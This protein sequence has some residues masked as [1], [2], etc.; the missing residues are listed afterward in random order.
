MADTNMKITDAS[1][2]TTMAG[3]DKMFV[4]SGGDLKQIELD[5]AV[6]A[7]EPVKTLNS[8]L[9]NIIC[10]NIPRNTPKDITSYYTDGSLWNRLNGSGGYQFLE[11]I[12]VGDYIKMSRAISAKNPDSTYQATGS[13]YVT[14]ASINGL[15]GN[16][17]TGVSYNHLVMVPGTG[18]GGTQ[19]FG[20]SYMNSSHTTTGGYK[21]SYMNTTLLGDV[22]SSG[23]TASGATINQQLYA[24]F[25]SHLKTTRELVSNQINASG[26]G[27][28]GS[29]SGCSNGWEWISAQAIL[30]SEIEVYGSV[31]FG[32]SGYDIGNANH[33]LELFTHSKSAINNRSAYYWLKDVASAARFCYCDDLGNSSCGS[34]GAGGYFV[35]PRFVIAA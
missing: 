31:V 3:T 32:S 14:I 7:S 13:Q 16:G 6:A 27:R 24:E 35:R 28:L 34:A 23:S 11:D 29:A 15:M 2:I 33:Q 21:S 8:N 25:G 20:R 17:D 5:K 30:M 10:H 19:H 12:F 26:Y 22:V 18:N 9:G 1:T 4:N